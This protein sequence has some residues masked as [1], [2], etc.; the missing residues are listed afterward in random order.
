MSRKKKKNKNYY[1]RR[2]KRFS[3]PNY[4]KQAI[5]GV[6][7][8]LVAVLISLSFFGKAGIAG[9][10]FMEWNMFLIGETIFVFPLIFILGGL[11][12]LSKKY[13]FEL[14]RK[15]RTLFWPVILAV[16]LLVLGVTGILAVF[17]SGSMNGGII[18]YGLSWPFLKYFGFWATFFIFLTPIV[19]GGLIFW[20]FLRP[21]SKEK[22]KEKEEEL[23][24]ALQGKTREGKPS[25]IKKI[26]APR[27]KVRKI[28]PSISSVSL[29]NTS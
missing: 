2:K 14:F 19:I 17:N 8:I 13:D 23:S 12:L 28:S 21:V 24:Q 18:G 3:F 22:K 5:W 10:T 9:K 11:I 27:F 20:P 7:M 16:L 15:D 25:I 6:L 4:T 29:V 1:R 26:F